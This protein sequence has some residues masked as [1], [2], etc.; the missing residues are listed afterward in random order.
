MENDVISAL[1]RPTQE[2]LEFGTRLEFIMK[3][4]LTNEEQNPY[5]V[6]NYPFQIVDTLPTSFQCRVTFMFSKLRAL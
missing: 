5:L 4:H 3:S 2:V 1:R 6:Q